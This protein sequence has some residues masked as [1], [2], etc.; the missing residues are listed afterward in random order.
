[1]WQ[2][3]SKGKE[4]EN[5]NGGRGRGRKRS[6]EMFRFAKLLLFQVNRELI[7]LTGTL[8]VIASTEL[9]S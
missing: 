9:R 2:E 8:Q 1:M 7:S 4:N 6:R 3:I 5:E